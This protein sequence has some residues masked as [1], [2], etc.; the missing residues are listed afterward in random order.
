VP[1]FAW[2][3]RD[4]PL[5]SVFNHVYVCVGAVFSI[6]EKRESSP[7]TGIIDRLPV[8][9]ASHYMVRI[10]CRHPVRFDFSVVIL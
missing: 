2:D 5:F 7:D 4:L 9:V 6:R 10:S 8:Q 3:P 1:L